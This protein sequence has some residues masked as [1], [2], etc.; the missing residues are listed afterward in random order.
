MRNMLGVMWN[1]SLG[2]GI[3][4]IVSRSFTSGYFLVCDVDDP[5]PMSLL[6]SFSSLIFLRNYH[7][8]SSSS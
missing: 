4:W 2:C 3:V 6:A 8:S 7:M 1:V 5:V